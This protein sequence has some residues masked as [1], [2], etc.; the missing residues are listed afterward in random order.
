M[1]SRND[2]AG[3]TLAAHSAGTLMYWPKPPEVFMPKSN[4]V[5]VTWSPTANMRVV[6]VATTPAASMPGV[7]GYLRVTPLLPLAD[8]AS[9]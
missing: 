7:C 5:T 4:P 6:E 3:G 9:L 1:L 2:S 8:S